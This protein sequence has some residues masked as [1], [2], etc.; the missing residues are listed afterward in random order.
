MLTQVGAS[1]DH[2]AVDLRTRRRAHAM[3]IHVSA[4][5]SGAH[6]ELG[7]KLTDDDALCVRTGEDTRL[8]LPYRDL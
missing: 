2:G 3:D 4:R 7:L 6:D 1:V 8:A 5:R